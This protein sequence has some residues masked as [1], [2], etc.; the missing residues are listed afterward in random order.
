MI[1]LILNIRI[2]IFASNTFAKFRA[3]K[4]LSFA[5]T[6]LDK[7]KSTFF[8]QPLFLQLHPFF[9]LFFLSVNEW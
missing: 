7:K 1:L 8:K 2:A 9:S 6:I 3:L 5:F 4:S